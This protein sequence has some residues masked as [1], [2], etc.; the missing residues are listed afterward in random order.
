MRDEAVCFRAAQGPQELQAV[1]RF[2][3]EHFFNRFAAGYPGVDH[4]NRLVCEPHDHAATHLCALDESGR[5]AAV[6]TAVPAGLGCIPETWPRWFDFD[7]LGARLL[8]RTVVSTRMVL[9]PRLRHTAFFP[10]FHQSILRHYREAGFAL[11]VHY[12]RPD[13]LPRYESL[14]HRGYHTCFSLPTGQLRAPMLIAFEENAGPGL[15]P[16]LGLGLPEGSLR[17]ALSRMPPGRGRAQVA[18]RLAASGARAAAQ[19]LPENLDQALCFASLLRLAKGQCLSTA[20][21]EAYFGLILSG[22]FL[23]DDGGPAR[24]LG[25]GEFMGSRALHGVATGL[26]PG[27]TASSAAT[28]GEMLV[29]APSLV[30]LATAHFRG[31]GVAAGIVDTGEVWEAVCGAGAM[32]HGPHPCPW[33]LHEEGRACGTPS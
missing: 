2:R 24:R 6:S 25:P 13:M 10:W 12:C 22:E 16:G 27:F 32:A 23:E 3:Y 17:P 14:G 1:F 7:G 31:D 26:P 9:H 30:R 20:P 28:D 18:A 33:P 11:A 5:L 8:K 21:D 15:E 4:S 29:F 19:G